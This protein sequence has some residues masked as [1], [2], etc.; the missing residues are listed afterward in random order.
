MNIKYKFYFQVNR[1]IA[2]SGSIHVEITAIDEEKA[3]KKLY[4]II[5]P[6]F[7]TKLQKVVEE[8]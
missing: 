1:G 2:P 4:K 8:N 7:T 6:E 5:M 3:R